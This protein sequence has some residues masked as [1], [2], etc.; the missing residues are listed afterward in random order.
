M[1][2]SHTETRREPLLSK[3]L[4]LVV[5]VLLAG[6]DAAYSFVEKYAPEYAAEAPEPVAADD[7]SIMQEVRMVG[8]AVVLI[9]VIVLVVNEVL[10]VPAINNSTGPF[11]PVIDS[12]GTTGVAAMSLLV[13]G[14]VVAAARAIMGFM[15]GGF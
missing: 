13:V 12:L 14:L 8:G 10:T 6:Y 11:T 5:S 1:A 2:V 9:A 7:L 4:M 15:G 3:M